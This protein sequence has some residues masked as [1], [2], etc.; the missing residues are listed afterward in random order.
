MKSSDPK[1]TPEPIGIII[2]GLPSAPSATVFSAYVW[3]PAPNTNDEPVRE[4]V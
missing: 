3:G 2:A 4:A 1:G